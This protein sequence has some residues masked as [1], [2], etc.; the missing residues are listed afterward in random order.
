LRTLLEHDLTGT[1][2]G[3]WLLHASGIAA[4]F[5]PAL[6]AGAVSAR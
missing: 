4:K 2:T 3:R 6:R 5:S 1:E